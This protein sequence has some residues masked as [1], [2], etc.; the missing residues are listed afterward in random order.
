MKFAFPQQIAGNDNG[1]LVQV[2]T[3]R[4][5]EPYLNRYVA[6]IRRGLFHRSCFKEA[7]DTV[8]SH[9]ESMVQSG[10]TGPRLRTVIVRW[11]PVDIRQDKLG[12]DLRYGKQPI[13][14]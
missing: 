8:A 1:G 2:N 11:A 9:D 10:P 6:G 12:I 3:R 14:G 5:V 4:G 7:L 13:Q